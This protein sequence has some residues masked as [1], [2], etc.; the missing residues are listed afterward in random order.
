METLTQAEIATLAREFSEGLVRDLERMDRKQRRKKKKRR[1]APERPPVAV[2]PKP[3]EEP[4]DD[5]EPETDE[6][7]PENCTCAWP[8][9]KF[10]NG[11]GHR[12][13]CPVHQEW[14]AR[15]GFHPVSE[16]EGELHV[17]PVIVEH[18][19]GSIRAGVTKEGKPWRT[20][21][22]HDYGFI[23]DT[24]T[25]ADNSE[26]DIYVGPD[27]DSQKVFVIDQVDPK[28][29]AWDE[30]KVM[31]GFPDEDS[32]KAGY[33]AHYPDDWKGFGHITEMTVEEFRDWLDGDNANTPLA[34]KYQAA[35]PESEDDLDGEVETIRR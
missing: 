23:P 9:E 31:I 1:E 4:E 25:A 7:K 21:M 27:P 16:T 11:S 3:P 15:G 30:H 34:E 10:R 26:I 20:L 18:P 14:L 28:T 29:A 5:A 19:K 13:D 35:E 12:R 22:A 24:L 2:K 32:A 17:L 8:E 33:F 6:Q